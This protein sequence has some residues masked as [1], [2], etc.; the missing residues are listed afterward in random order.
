MDQSPWY[1]L[2]VSVNQ[3]KK[4]AQHLCVRT[5]EHYL[6]L[7]TE[8]SRWSDRTVMLERPLFSGYV[9]VRFSSGSRLA[10]ISTPG[11][12]RLL[13]SGP[14][15]TVSSQELDRIRAGLASGSLTPYPNLALGTRVR[16]RNGAF[17]GVEGVVTELRQRCRVVIELTAIRQSFSL[18]VKREDFEI[19]PAV[20]LKKGPLP[21]REP[22][23][24]GV[25]S[26]GDH[27][28]ADIRP[29]MSTHRNSMTRSG[30]SACLKGPVCMATATSQVL[31]DY[32]SRSASLTSGVRASAGEPIGSQPMS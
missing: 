6:P 3:E 31:G 19:L 10:V 21:S 23:F 30:E 29:C 28:G 2:H 32:R 27:S 15:D 22:G 1:V 12:I 18:E 13:G 7:Y 4:V 14:T 8:H 26:L 20:S 25:R 11:V 5:I 17:Q 9:F 16:V 24:Y